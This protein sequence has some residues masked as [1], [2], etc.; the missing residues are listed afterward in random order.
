MY[1]KVLKSG[2]LDVDYLG[3]I[4]EFSVVSLQ[5]LSAP[6]NE[7]IIKAKHKTLFSEL[8]EICQS[9]DE[10]NNACV[11]ALVKGLQFVLE[12]IQVCLPFLYLFFLL[13]FISN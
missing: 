8:N 7:E 5:K 4:L 10:S 2:K 12:Q 6:A 9:R 3:K 11:V 13:Y 1:L